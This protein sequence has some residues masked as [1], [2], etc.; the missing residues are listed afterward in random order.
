[1]A[2]LE[3]ELEGEDLGLDAPAYLQPMPV[4]P[5]GAP[6][7]A[8]VAPAAPISHGGAAQQVDEYGLPI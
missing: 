5:N 8:P 6:V 4:Q 2:C 7:I 1:M 3:D